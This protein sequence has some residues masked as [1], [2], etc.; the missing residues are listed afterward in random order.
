MYF[1]L[2]ALRR[3]L[4]EGGDH[5]I[6][7]HPLVGQAVPAEESRAKPALHPLVGQ[8]APAEESRAQPDPPAC[9]LRVPL[10]HA[11]A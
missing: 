3:R 5:L 8:A 1:H 4:K 6:D 7:L 9:K 2:G 10:K 11:L